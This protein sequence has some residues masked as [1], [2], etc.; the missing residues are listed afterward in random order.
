MSQIPFGRILLVVSN[1]FTA[2][3]AFAFD[4]S[5]THVFNPRWPPHAKFHNGQTMSLSLALVLLTSYLCFRTTS[6]LEQSRDSVWIATLVSSI[7]GLTGLSA[8]LYPGTDWQD[9]EFETSDKG[10]QMIVFSSVVVAAWV[11]Y[12]I[13]RWRLGDDNKV[14]RR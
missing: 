1:I 12:L 5:T 11:G 14:K 7:Y 4:W 10:A 9:P 3:G 8:I 6:S 2:G 13:E